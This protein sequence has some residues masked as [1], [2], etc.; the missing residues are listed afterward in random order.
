MHTQ[1][2]IG[3]KRFWRSF[4][5]NTGHQ[6]A[7]TSVECSFTSQ[8]IS[9]NDGNFSVWLIERKKTLTNIFVT[10][11]ISGGKIRTYYGTSVMITLNTP[12]PF[13]SLFVFHTLWFLYRNLHDQTQ[14]WMPPVQSSSRPRYQA[15]VM[16][17]MKRRSR[18]RRRRPQKMAAATTTSG[19]IITKP[20]MI[21]A[22]Q[23]LSSR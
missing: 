15:R 2:I 8:S 9:H 10:E 4:F 6:P 5:M 1:I 7:L 20:R 13:I 21:R 17:W 18:N 23:L 16:G 14:E 11:P 3:P 12:C 22:E 19:D